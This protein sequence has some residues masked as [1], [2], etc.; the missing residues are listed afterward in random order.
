MHLLASNYYY[1]AHT[2]LTSKF[3][4]FITYYVGKWSNIPQ[5]LLLSHSK[6][7]PIFEIFHRGGYINFCQFFIKFLVHFF[8]VYK[9]GCI[10]DFVLFYSSIKNY[11]QFCVKLKY[12]SAS[13]ANT[14]C[15]IYP[16]F[17][18]LYTQKLVPK[19]A[20]TLEVV[21]VGVHL[22]YFITPNLVVYYYYHSTTSLL[23]T[24]WNI[25]TTLVLL[26][27]Y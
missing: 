4:L 12:H 20:C 21:V 19:I 8:T 2:I 25:T 13:D 23:L 24:W 26:Y 9:I 22:Y 7:L 14:Y 5:I 3:S 16:C 15:F 27:Y 6:N 17:G 1:F 10:Q 11:R 18:P